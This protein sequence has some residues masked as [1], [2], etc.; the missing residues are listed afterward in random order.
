MLAEEW[1]YPELKFIS[2]LLYTIIMLPGIHSELVWLK[3]ID[4]NKIKN[5]SKGLYFYIKLW[6]SLCL[7]IILYLIC[8]FVIGCIEI[9]S[10]ANLYQIV[11]VVCIDHIII[12]ITKY[13]IIKITNGNTPNLEDYFFLTEINAVLKF[14]KDGLEGLEN[15]PNSK[16]T[17]KNVQ[18]LFWSK[19]ILDFTCSSFFDG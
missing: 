18:G 4:S 7:F 14:Q 5:E 11:C 6:S 8:R 16:S 13:N 2:T 10:M 17:L 15:Y 12:N 19:S 1:H 9:I 3:S